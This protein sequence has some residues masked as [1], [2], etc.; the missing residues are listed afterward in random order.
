MKRSESQSCRELSPSFQIRPVSTRIRPSGFRCSLDRVQL[1]SRW[2]VGY[3]YLSSSRTVL[4]PVNK[5][6]WTCS[7][8]SHAGFNL[9]PSSGDRPILSRAAFFA[10]DSVSFR[11][12]I[13]R[14]SS[15]VI[16]ASF[17][18]VHR[19]DC[20]QIIPSSSPNHETCSHTLCFGLAYS[21]GSN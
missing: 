9:H 10:Q 13:V 21:G 4:L 6:S 8:V 5:L 18:A 1:M 17:L 7:Q 14:L 19:V 15:C 3:Y 12:H 20:S 16:A 11:S 2:T